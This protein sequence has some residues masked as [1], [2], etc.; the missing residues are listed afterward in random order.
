M[1]QQ[2][3]RPRK[4]PR[5]PAGRRRRLPAAAEVTSTV[6]TFPVVGLGASAGGLEALEV[7]FRHMPADSGMA[8]VVVTH[9]SPTHVSLLPELLG[10]CTTMLV[11]QATDGVALEANIVYTAPPNRYVSLQH[12][13]MHLLEAPPGTNIR[14]PIDVFFCALAEDQQDSAIGIVL[15]GTS[16]D[17]TLGLRAIK[18]AFGMIMVQS[19]KSAEYDGMPQSALA[20]GLVDY[21]LAP[22]EMP[23]QLQAYLTNPSPARRSACRGPLR[24]APD[25]LPAVTAPYGA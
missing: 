21:V 18:D 6:G 16:T 3:P 8:F 15:S 2:A 22:A 19:V 23:A 25:H 11:R 20:T 12:G 7:F 9:Q 10:R 4:A 1:D 5:T 14:F 13:T 17:G 24:G